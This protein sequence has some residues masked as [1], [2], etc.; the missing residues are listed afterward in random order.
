MLYRRCCFLPVKARVRLCFLRLFI[1][2][3]S[4]ADNPDGCAPLI[5]A[6]PFS[7]ANDMLTGTEVSVTSMQNLR[8]RGSMTKNVFFPYT[9]NFKARNA[10][11]LINLSNGADLHNKSGLQPQAY[12]SV[13]ALLLPL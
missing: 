4:Q 7:Q 9:E 12:C 6:A 3:D 10:V 5:V 11:L 8:S 2:T 1:V 13:A